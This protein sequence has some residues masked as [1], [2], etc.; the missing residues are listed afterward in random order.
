MKHYK[1]YIQQFKC[2]K[3]T[4]LLLKNLTVFTGGNGCGKSSVIQALLFLRRTIE[5]CS[6]WIP[7]EKKYKYESPNGLN[8]ELNGAYCL[9]LGNSANVLWIDAKTNDI[10]IGLKDCTS[11][12]G[13]FSVKYSTIGNEQW[14]TPIEITNNLFNNPLYYQEFYYLNAERIGPRINQE[15]HFY[16]YP[17]VGFKG[18]FTAQI[19]EKLNFEKEYGEEER[20]KKR[21][22]TERLEGTRFIHYVNSW[23]NYIL[24]GISVD[25]A[26]DSDTLSARIMI[27]DKFSRGNY[28][29]PTNTGFGISCLLPIIVTGIAAKEDRFFVIEN[30]EAH[31]HPA[32]QSRVGY[33]LGK[34]AAAGVRIIIETH[35][36]HI[37]NGIQLA[38]ADK[39]IQCQD[40]SINY[41]NN[42]GEEGLEILN[43]PI[44]EFGEITCWPKGFFDQSQIDY[45]QLLKYKKQ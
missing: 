7:S 5:H 10:T 13:C 39:T 23:L 21:A 1:L 28:V 36:D 14:I 20:R 26:G 40:V 18:E 24:D 4:E 45:L 41:F 8:V 15:T 29:V 32:A 43:L 38:V 16:D 17:N 2:L 11:G 37:L 27:L 3:D 34:I 35:S 42:S 22:Y 33:F 19:I 12:D 9:N 6:T 30:P 31:L 44:T 25:T